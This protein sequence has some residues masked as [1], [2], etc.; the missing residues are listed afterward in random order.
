MTLADHKLAIL[1]GAGRWWWGRER[2]SELGYH[3]VIVD[4]GIVSHLLVNILFLFT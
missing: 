1:G 3:S 2:D 4:K